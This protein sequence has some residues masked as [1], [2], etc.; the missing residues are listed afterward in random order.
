MENS[1]ENTHKSK[2]S[3]HKAHLGS[4]KIA[5]ASDHLPMTDLGSGW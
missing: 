5:P 1:S 3:L 4:L 2:S